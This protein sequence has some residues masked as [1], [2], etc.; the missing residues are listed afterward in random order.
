[1]QRWAGR[2]QPLAMK[3]STIPDLANNAFQ[4]HAADAEGRTVLRR[5]APA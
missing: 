2:R 4:L 5:R 1:M 3:I